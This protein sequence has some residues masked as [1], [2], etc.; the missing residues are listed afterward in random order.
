MLKGITILDCCGPPP[1]DDDEGINVP[2]RAATSFLYQADKERYE[3]GYYI[4]V[5]YSWNDDIEDCVENVALCLDGLDMDTFRNEVGI[6][7]NLKTPTD[8]LVDP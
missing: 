6:L 8:R 1:E 3:T 2:G 4:T 7:L 5:R